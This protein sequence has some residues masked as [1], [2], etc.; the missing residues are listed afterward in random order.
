MD[1]Y[2]NSL[3]ELNLSEFDDLTVPTAEQLDEFLAKGWYRMQ[4]NLFTVHYIAGKK[5]NEINPAIWLRV[6]IEKFKKSKSQRQISN[7][8]EKKFKIEVRKALF[9]KK[10][11]RLY[12]N[13]TKNIRWRSDSFY[14]LEQPKFNSWEVCIYDGPELI[15]FSFFDLGKKAISSIVGIYHPDYEKYSLGNY[16]MI[17]EIE[18]GRQNGFEYYYP[19]YFVIGNPDFDYKLKFLPIEFYR[20]FTKSWHPISDFSETDNITKYFEIKLNELSNFLTLQNIENQVIKI[21]TDAQVFLFEFRDF[22]Y[23]LD[24]PY[25]LILKPYQPATAF[26][27]V[28]YDVKK[29]KYALCKAK[30]PISLLDYFDFFNGENSEDFL[31]IEDKDPE[32]FNYALDKK[33]LEIAEIIAYCDTPQAVFD[34]IQDYNAQK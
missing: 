15:A 5:E 19:G 11:A 4:D 8:I 12:E 34:S 28:V 27:V 2:F 32:G 33:G 13:Y 17:A 6:P 7:R 3:P 16:T 1:L 22:G 14:T 10:K 31:I 9:D 18:F 24:H 30:H 26:I 23:L 29:S 21:S 25:G 20:I